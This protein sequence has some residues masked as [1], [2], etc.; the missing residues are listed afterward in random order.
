MPISITATSC[1]RSSF[2][3]CRGRPN[4][5]FKFPADF[6][7]LNF[8]ANTCATASFVVLF[9]ADPLTPITPPP[10]SFLTLLPSPQSTPHPSPP[11][12]CEQPSATPAA[13]IHRNPPPTTTAS[14]PPPPAPPIDSLQ[15]PPRL[16]SQAPPAHNHARPSAHLAPQRTTLPRQSSASRSHTPPPPP[17]YRTPHPHESNPQ[18]APMSASLKSS[19]FN[20]HKNRVPHISILTCGHRAQH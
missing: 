20:C 14:H 18:P 15:P 16:H 17:A 5:L 4:A 3:N 10:P 13:H 8:V 1:S 12:S 6:S 19:L 2:S 9:P 11:L 7:T